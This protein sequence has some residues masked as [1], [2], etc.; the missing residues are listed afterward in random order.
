MNAGVACYGVLGPHLDLAGGNC[1][2]EMDVT[3]KS[4]DGVSFDVFGG[5]RYIVPPR[6]ERMA[7]FSLKQ[8]TQGVEFRLA[9]PAGFTGR[10]NKIILRA[11]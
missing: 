9:V 4:F 2:V 6:S 10:L 11:P 1:V 7:A 3:A 5:G 8:P